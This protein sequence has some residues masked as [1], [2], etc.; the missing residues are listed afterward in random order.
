MQF[1]SVNEQ[2]S[3]DCSVCGTRQEAE[4]V[5]YVVTVVL[6]EYIPPS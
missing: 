2:M 5:W 1:R 4:E 6:E 3:L